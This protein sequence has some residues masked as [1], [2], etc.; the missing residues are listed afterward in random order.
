MLFEYES[1]PTAGGHQ[2]LDP[3]SPN[4][5]AKDDLYSYK[6]VK[7]FGQAP[8][9]GVIGDNFTTWNRYIHYKSD[10]GNTGITPPSSTNPYV[11]PNACSSGSPGYYMEDIN[12]PGSA[13][14]NH[15]F[16]ESPSISFSSGLVSGD[17]YELRTGVLSPFVQSSEQNEYTCLF[18]LNISNGEY[19]PECPSGITSDNYNSLHVASNF[20]TFSRQIKW[21]NYGN[22]GSQASPQASNYMLT[23]N[24]FSL[25]SDPF[26]YDNFR[27]QIGPAISDNDFATLPDDIVDPLGNPK[28]CESYFLKNLGCTYDPDDETNACYHVASGDPIPQNFGLG[29][30]WWSNMG[31]YSPYIPS[32]QYIVDVCNNQTC[33]G[34]NFW[35]NDGSTQNYPNV[36]T[37]AKTGII[38]LRYAEIVRYAKNPLVLKRVKHLV[39]HH[40][41]DPCALLQHYIDFPLHKEEYVKNEIELDYEIAQVAR[42]TYVLDANQNGQSKTF[43]GDQQN[44]IL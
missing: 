15:G 36:P 7:Q 33:V 2:L 1:L 31:F 29:I 18:D 34:N 43:P 12:T 19:A 16:L 9:T 22:S 40:D 23:S 24:Y 10:N 42:Y 14:F 25:P 21:Y 44:A 30:P 32:L 5:F 26:T 37:R 8:G 3:T 6:S 39:D 13:Y 11:G 41:K 35:W 4:V 20:S 28:V 38:E 17:I 27:I